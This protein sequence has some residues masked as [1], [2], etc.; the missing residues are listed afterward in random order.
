[1]KSRNIKRM[2]TVALAATMVLGSTMTA[3]AAAGESEGAGTYEGGE[4]QYPTLSVTL[5]TIPDHTYDYIADPNGLIAATSAAHYD[6]ATFTGNS[7]IFFKT[8]DANGDTKATYTDTSKAQEVTNNNAQDI[9]VTVKLE[10]KTAGDESIMYADSATFETTDTANKLYLAV[11]DGATQNPNV[12]ALSSTSA[13]TVSTKVEGKTSNYLPSY[14]STNNK[15]EYRLKTKAENNDTDLTWNSCSFKLTGAL[16]KNA[17]WGDDLDFPTIKVTWS[18]AEHTDSPVA[19]P[20]SMSTSV[21]SATI[22]NL[23]E[24]VTLSSVQVVKA[25]SSIVTLTSGTQY[26]FTGNTF[27]IVS[28]KEVLLNPETYKKYVLTFSDESVVEI[29]IVAAD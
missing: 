26:T 18:Y 11:T 29:S 16:N 2:L 7:G 19:N 1:M 21:K 3:F 13:A 24:G 9:D 14:D 25:D 8:T 10:Q 23:G 15:Y 28:G 17:T 27:A 20:S 5:P 22:Q 12:D 6:G 4:M